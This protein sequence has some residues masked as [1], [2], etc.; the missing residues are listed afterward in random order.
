MAIREGIVRFLR[1]FKTTFDLQVGDSSL[2]PFH[3]AT[4]ND[5]KETVRV[6]LRH[7]VD[8][9]TLNPTGW[10]AMQIVAGYNRREMA[11]VLLEHGANVNEVGIDGR[12]GLHVAA[13]NGSKVRK[14]LSTFIVI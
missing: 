5:N 1:D 2:T 4:K 13:A 11:N 3:I 9:N 14:C 7:G 12:S 8:V 6:L 10:N